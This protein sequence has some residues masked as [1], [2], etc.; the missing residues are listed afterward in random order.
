MAD[1][2]EMAEHTEYAEWLDL[3]VEGE[4]PPAEARRLEEHLAG[5]ADCRAERQ[6]LV[7]LRRALDEVRI[8]VRDGFRAQVMASLPE[9]AWATAAGPTAASTAEPAAAGSRRAFG[10]AA[11]LLVALGAATAFLFALGGGGLAGLPGA[12]VAT[13]LGE[14]AVATLVTGAGLL[15]AS[16]AGVGLALGEMFSSAPGVLVA[17][18]LLLLFLGGLL[19]TLLRRPAAARQRSRD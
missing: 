6:R 13:A 11:L 17:F 2:S 12:G 15:G 7:H 9:P 19:V 5:C 1:H 10:L 4:L 18:A 3:Q 14:M 16:W 8:P